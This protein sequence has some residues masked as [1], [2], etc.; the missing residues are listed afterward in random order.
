M[1]RYGWSSLWLAVAMVLLA[2]LPRLDMLGF[3]AVPVLQAL[4]PLFCLVAAVAAAVMALRR[5]WLAT[6]LLVIGVLLAI[7]PTLVPV[8][9][10]SKAS[11]AAPLTIFSINVEFSRADAAALAENIKAFHAD[12]VVLIEVEEPLISDVLSRGLREQLPYRTPT[13]TSS[14]DGGTAI[15]SRYPLAPEG[16]IPVADGIAAFDQ[17]SAVID[18]PGFGF[19]RVAGVHPYAPIVAGGG[20][21][22]QILRSLDSWQAQHREIPL[23]MAGDFNSTSA[24][25]AFRDLASSFEDT[26]A[27]AGMLPVPTWPATLPGPAFLAIDHILARG[28]VATG[29][30]RVWIPGTDHYGVVATVTSPESASDS[31]K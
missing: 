28:L 27:A 14:G 11:S 4:V 19:L 13:L 6:L 24:H 2:V 25:P 30:Q 21:W 31:N 16:N 10:A 22:K 23:I 26:A 15:L 17:P 3:G 9:S 7:V 29:W 1:R 8:V 18:H 12:V 5:R 20:T